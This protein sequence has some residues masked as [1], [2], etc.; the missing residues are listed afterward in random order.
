MLPTPEA[1]SGQAGGLS[2]RVALVPISGVGSGAR[3]LARHSGL[4]SK[5]A[6]AAMIRFVTSW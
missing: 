1:F 2:C 4:G 3:G 5:A 6:I